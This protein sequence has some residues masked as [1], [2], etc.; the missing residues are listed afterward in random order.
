[1]GSSVIVIALF[2]LLG[3]E[4]NTDRHKQT[5][6]GKNKAYHTAAAPSTPS[7]ATS[8]PANTM[9]FVSLYSVTKE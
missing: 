7:L 6:V 8:Q 2:E 3:S 9:P 4:R 1:M 5:D